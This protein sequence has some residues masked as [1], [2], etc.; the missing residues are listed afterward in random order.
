[1]GAVAPVVRLAGN[2]ERHLDVLRWGL[3][4]WRKYGKSADVDTRELRL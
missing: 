1:M 3:V 4:P 2:G